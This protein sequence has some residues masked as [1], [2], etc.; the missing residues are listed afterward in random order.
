MAKDNWQFKYGY[1]WIDSQL[2]IYKKRDDYD[3]AKNR[4]DHDLILRVMDNDV[5]FARFAVASLNNRHNYINVSAEVESIKE[6][7]NEVV[8]K[9]RRRAWLFPVSLK[10]FNR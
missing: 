4:G 3:Y 1:C 10:G 9:P 5:E 2:T 6:V 7:F 8:D